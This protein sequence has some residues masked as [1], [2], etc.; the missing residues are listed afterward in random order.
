MPVF[1][2]AFSLSGDINWQNFLISFVAI[3]LFLY[4]ASNGFNSYFDKDEKSIGG[5]KSPP[6]VT[7]E[8]YQAALVFDALAIGAGLLISWQFS[9][10][11]F[12]YGL[13]SKAYSH[14]GIRLKKL[15]VTSWL[16]IGI[17]QGFFTYL[18][19]YIAL[20]GVDLVELGRDHYLP[21]AL[22]TIMLLGSYPMTQVYQHEEDKARG[23]ITL[24]LRLGVLGT[25]HFTAL[26][27]TSSAAL[28]IWYFITYLDIY[29]VVVYLSF[30]VPILLF[31]GTWYLRTRKDPSNADFRNTM[32]LNMISSTSLSAF[33][34]V[35]RW[36]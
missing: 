3:H 9:L 10:M 5:L 6:P 19:S 22:S 18:M 31:F 34:I 28:F 4:P 7:K 12:I 30:M 21:A 35:L 17:F 8:L 26:V 33:F 27:F 32:V 24:S 15:P 2:F 29:V 36:I 20:N 1:L 16:V 11:L 13:V 14:P 23:D 25:F